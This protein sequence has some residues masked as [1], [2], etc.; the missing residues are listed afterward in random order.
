MWL[1]HHDFLRVLQQA[2]S[3]DKALQE[4]TLEFVIR[5][6]KWNCEVFGNLFARKED[7]S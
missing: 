3:E 4:A 7:I 5:V 2:W 1:L 6:R